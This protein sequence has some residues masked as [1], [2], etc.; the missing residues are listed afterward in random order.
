M[1]YDRYIVCFSGGKDSIACFLHLLDMGVPKEKIELWHHDIDGGQETLFDWEV[2]PYYC[3]AFAKA[4][5][6]PIYFSWKEGGFEREMLRENQKTAPIIFEDQNHFLHSTGGTRGK[7]NTRRKFPQVSPDLMV[8]WCSPY[9]KIDVAA[10][11]IRHQS[12]FEYGKTVVITGERAQ[13]SDSKFFEKDPE[14]LKGRGAYADLE[15]DRSDNRNGKRVRRYVDHWRP[16]K[17]WK[18]E[19]V[20]EIIER[21]RVIPHPAYYLGW[22]RVSCKFCIFGGDNQF[23]SANYISPKCGSK[24]QEYEESFEVTLKRDR[25]LSDMYK[26]GTVYP[27]V[28]QNKQ[29]VQVATTHAYDLPIIADDDVEWELPS[30]AYK[31]ESCGPK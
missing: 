11:A 12:R 20:W 18:E 25:S 24:L 21:Y 30:G 3:R 1:I 22:S 14:K 7:E 29:M 9:L 17:L 31:S 27:Q 26:N 8:R 13:E 2:T 19:K 16:I 15:P 4:F 6:V 23:A 5:G 10:A 28:I